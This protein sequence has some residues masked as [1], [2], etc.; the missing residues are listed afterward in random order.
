MHMA[1]DQAGHQGAAAGID[2]LAGETGKFGSRRHGSDAA[3]LDQNALTGNR[4]GN[5]VEYKS[6]DEKLGHGC[7]S[8]L[9]LVIVGL[10]MKVCRS[11]ARSPGQV[12]VKTYEE[13]T[14]PRQIGR[15]SCRERVCQYV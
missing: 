5:A 4:F 15:A 13:Y 14:R 3:L 7:C 10:V 9:S 12:K 8:R 6:T 11:F 2:G 1:V